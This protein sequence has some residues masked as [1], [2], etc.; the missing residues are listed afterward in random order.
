MIWDVF[1]LRH[2][3]QDR[4]AGDNFL[5]TSDPH[6]APMPL[7]FFVWLSRSGDRHVLVDTGFSPETADRRGRRL[8]RSVGQALRQIGVEPR[9]VE[10]VVI[11]LT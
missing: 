10:D 2:A 1:G 9:T 7:D 11:T 6:D 8:I 3:S 4:V 5:H